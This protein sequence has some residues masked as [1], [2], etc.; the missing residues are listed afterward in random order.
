[1]GRLNPNPRAGL[2]CILPKIHK[3]G[4]PGRLIIFSNGPPLNAFLHSL[5]ITWIVWYSHFRPTSKTRPT[6]FTNSSN[7]LQSP[8][9]LSFLRLMFHH[10]IQTYN[11]THYNQ[12]SVFKGLKSLLIRNVMLRLYKAFMLPHFHYCSLIWHFCGARN[13]DK[14]ELLIK[15]ILRFI[16]TIS[17]H[18]KMQTSPPPYMSVF[19]ARPKPITSS[20]TPKKND[21]YMIP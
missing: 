16:S 13:R 8:V 9:M 2:L 7:L 14:L 10:Y 12:F 15:G 17:W 4:N 5:I 18:F 20:P 21:I 1:M 3:Q 19:T 6:F 11:I